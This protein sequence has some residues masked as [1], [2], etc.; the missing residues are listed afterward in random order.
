[1]GASVI[2]ILD[3]NTCLASLPPQ[4]PAPAFHKSTYFVR[5]IDLTL[6]ITAY[7][8]HHFVRLVTIVNSLQT[9]EIEGKKIPGWWN[10]LTTQKSSWKLESG[11]GVS[12]LMRKVQVSSITVE[13]SMKHATCKTPTCWISTAIDTTPLQNSIL[14]KRE[15]VLKQRHL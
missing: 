9:L 1:M 11:R 3:T 8:N 12:V 5:L 14:E 2:L 4:P 13:K 6:G 15:L 10:I 7:I